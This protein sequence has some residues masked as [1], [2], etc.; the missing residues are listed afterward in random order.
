M[1][2]SYCDSG[3][4][5]FFFFLSFT[6]LSLY[7]SFPS[8][9]V[10]LLSFSFCLWLIWERLAHPFVYGLTVKFWNNPNVAGVYHYY[11]VFKTLS[12][13]SLFSFFRLPVF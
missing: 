3:Y 13:I 1:S 2:F 4:W 12:L 10:V 9:G 5:F 7:T 11:I 8:V 6:Y